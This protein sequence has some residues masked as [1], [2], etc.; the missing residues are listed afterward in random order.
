MKSLLLTLLSYLNFL[1]KPSVLILGFGFSHIVR[2]FGDIDYEFIYSL[3]FVHFLNVASKLYSIV[4]FRE[5]EFNL[6]TGFKR[7]IDKALLY[8][9]VFFVSHLLFTLEIKG[10]HPAGLDYFARYALVGVIGFE[11]SSVLKNLRV[12]KRIQEGYNFFKENKK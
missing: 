9:I 2:I 3:A 11:I 10:E 1:T 7:S 8:G 5:E 12:Y 4:K 6:C